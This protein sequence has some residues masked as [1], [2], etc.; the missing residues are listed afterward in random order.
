[1]AGFECGSTSQRKA[2]TWIFVVIRPVGGIVAMLRAQDQSDQAN[3]LTMHG[4]WTAP[5]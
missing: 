4:W 1:M 3:P 2:E 5:V